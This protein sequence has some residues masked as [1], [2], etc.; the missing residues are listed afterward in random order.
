MMF[1]RGVEVD[2]STINRK[3][4]LELDKLIRSHLNLNDVWT[5]T[6]S[7]AAN[8]QLRRWHLGQ[9]PLQEFE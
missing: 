1:E 3:Y 5:M 2:H 7:Q 8:L 4:A 6:D 9:F